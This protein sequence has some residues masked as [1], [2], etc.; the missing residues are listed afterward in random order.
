MPSS[1]TPSI[2]AGSNS[3]K[4]S[5]SSRWRT[6]HRAS[7][8]LAAVNWRATTTRS[9]LPGPMS[10]TCASTG[11][12]LS[13][14]TKM[15]SLSPAE[16]A[17]RTARRTAAPSPVAAPSERAKPSTITALLSAF[18]ISCPPCHSWGRGRT[19]RLARRETPGGRKG[20]RPASISFPVP[21]EDEGGAQEDLHVE[22]GGLVLD[23]E[24]VVFDPALDLLEGIG[25]A[26]PAVHLRL[27]GDA[28]LH[29]VAGGIGVH[30]LL[31]EPA[32]RLGRGR[33][34][35]RADQGHV[36]LEDVDELRQLV[37]AGPAQEAPHP[38]HPVVV[39]PGQYLGV[40]VGQVVVHGA[41]FPALEQIV[42]EAVAL[43][44]E[45]HRA[46]R[47]ELDG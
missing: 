41:E 1:R 44:P 36:T 33:V 7:P 35:A 2:S 15:S 10:P 27:G 9:G 38:R 24:E 26:P 31:V 46:P 12:R 16:S 40:G 25:F 43:L 30:R 42:V 29:A 23:V 18:V 45:E 4:G 13:A 39:A 5:S 17:S 21:Q 37:E 11:V 47:I 19:H 14:V 34:G 32:G 22:R 20:S 28:R 8:R 6:P 3:T